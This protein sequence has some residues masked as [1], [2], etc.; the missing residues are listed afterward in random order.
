MPPAT[1]IAWIQSRLATLNPSTLDILDESDRHR[2]HAGAK[3]GGHFQI[4]ICAEAFIGKSLL[5]RH[6]IVLALLGDLKA[7]GIHAVSISA[8]P[9][10]P[11]NTQ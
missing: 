4:N 10:K 11:D 5:Q 8:T 9:P 6:Q 3:E 7:A 2:G 1:A